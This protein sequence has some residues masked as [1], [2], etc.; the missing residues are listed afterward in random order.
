VHRGR[1]VRPE[2]ITD[3]GLLTV[4]GE[5]DDISG[6]GQTQA[7]HTLCSGIPA[8]LKQ[9]YVQPHVGHYGVFN[10]K[11]FHDEIYPRV[12]EFIWRQDLALSG[13]AIQAALPK[14][15]EPA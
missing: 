15:T 1:P 6:I 8:E 10:G 7:A 11:R 13:I 5:N 2:L 12:R 14:R 4:E 9:D 3:I